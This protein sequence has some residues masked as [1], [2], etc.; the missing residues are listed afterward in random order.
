MKI[1]IRVLLLIIVFLSSLV[2]S[3]EKIES[4]CLSCLIDYDWYISKDVNHY[5][6][7]YMKKKPKHIIIHHSASNDIKNLKKIFEDYNVSCHYFIDNKGKIHNVLKDNCTAYHAGISYWNGDYNLNNSSICIEILN[8]SPFTHDISKKQYEV[9]TKLINELK[10]KYDIKNY[11]IVSHSDIAYFNNLSN[12]QYL[13]RK[14]DISYLFS[15]KKL[16]KNNIGIWYNDN[17]I[18]KTNF[19]AL[20]YFGDKK[21]DLIDIKIKLKNIGYKVEKIDNEYDVEFFM[22]SIVFHR[23]FFSEQ[24]IMASQ[25]LWTKSS[26]YILDEVSK[27]FMIEKK[28]K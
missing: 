4:D 8:N 6:K 16:A 11:N 7:G 24:L 9:L 26:T 14:Q 13:N 23:R 10:N 17:K 21:D 2:F 20:Y 5:T 25:G 15:W 18:D 28:D 27:K 3:L 12:G 19:E 22:L 1:K